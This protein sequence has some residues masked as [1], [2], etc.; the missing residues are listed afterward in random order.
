[1]SDFPT[2][3]DDGKRPLQGQQPLKQCAYPQSHGRSIVTGELG[4][5]HA[6]TEVPAKLVR[7]LRTVL[8]LL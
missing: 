7:L 6:D 3:T 2:S 5:G 1:M 8:R 4:A